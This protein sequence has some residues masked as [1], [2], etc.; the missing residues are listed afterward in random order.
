MP[1]ETLSPALTG[2]MLL[3]DGHAHFEPRDVFK[4]SQ[5]FS[6]FGYHG[7][8]IKRR[9]TQVLGLD[10]G[11]II[12]KLSK[13]VPKRSGQYSMVPSLQ[14]VFRPM[15]PIASADSAAFGDADLSD[16]GLTVDDLANAIYDRMYEEVLPNFLA[17]IQLDQDGGL[18]RIA[19]LWDNER[20]FW[21]ALLLL[22]VV[23]NVVV[24]LGVNWT[25][26]QSFAF[27]FIQNRD[28]VRVHDAGMFN[29]IE[30]PSTRHWVVSSAALVASFEVLWI[31]RTL[32]TIISEM[33]HF[34]MSPNEYVAYHSVIRLCQDTLPLCSTFS[35]M[36]LMIRVHP[37]LIYSEYIDTVHHITSK[38]RESSYVFCRLV[39]WFVLTRIIFFSAA[40]MAFTVKLL[41][42]GLKLV[43]PQYSTLVRMTNVVSFMMQCMGCVLFEKLLQDRLFLFVFGG[44]DTEY[45]DDERALRNVYQCRMAKAIWDYYCERQER[46]KAVVLLFTINHYDVQRLLIEEYDADYEDDTQLWDAWGANAT[47]TFATRSLFKSKFVKRRSTRAPPAK[48][49]LANLT[50]NLLSNPSGARKADI[51]NTT[52]GLDDVGRYLL[53]PL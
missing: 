36:R 25:V 22:S 33:S 46:V 49:T 1:R 29:K 38:H 50:S 10:R 48:G 52:H 16:L 23:F 7:P 21:F 39:A 42:V 11:N 32:V 37:T 3:H 9:Y 20:Y 13:V 8:R 14:P 2:G 31:C 17:N 4:A 34:V 40:L 45:T 43:H 41:A 44:P 53:P 35:A 5:T 27:N 18:D 12:K 15:D 24:L 6:D 19:E 51:V 47:Q 28:E 26:F 30:D